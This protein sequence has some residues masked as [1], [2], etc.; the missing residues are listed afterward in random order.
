MTSYSSSLPHHLPSILNV[1]ALCG[2]A[3]QA[4]AAEVV[5][6]GDMVFSGAEVLDAIGY[7]TGIEVFFREDGDAVLLAR[8]QCAFL[9]VGRLLSEGIG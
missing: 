8:R 2:L 7:A 4:V 5:D 1:H 3:G 6:G 9:A